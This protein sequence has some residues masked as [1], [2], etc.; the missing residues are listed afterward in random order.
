RD[1]A[2]LGP[3][4]S[5]RGGTRRVARVGSGPSRHVASGSSGPP[6]TA[7]SQQP[8][9]NRSMSALVAWSASLSWSH[10]CRAVAVIGPAGSSVEGPAA[11][12]GKESGCGPIIS[13]SS[14]RGFGTVWGGEGEDFFFATGRADVE[15]VGAAG[16]ASPLLAGWGGVGCRVV[17]CR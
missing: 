2:P 8:T 15:D 6:P 5:R 1:T 16:A 12:S 4:A 10:A 17:S 9:A 13:R 3:V 7:N 14:P 11:R